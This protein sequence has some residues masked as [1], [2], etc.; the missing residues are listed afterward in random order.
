M[1]GF[2]GKK[3]RKI[4]NKV[5]INENIKWE[6]C[7]QQYQKN[8]DTAFIV[9]FEE[10]YEK[11]ISFFSVDN[12]PADNIFLTRQALHHQLQHV[13]VLFAEHHPLRTREEEFLDKHQL[14]HVTVYSSLD[15]PLLKHFGSSDITDLI[16]QSGMKE[17]EP[18]E[19]P[20][21]NTAIENAQNK[22]AEQVVL[23][24]AAFSQADW[25]MKNLTA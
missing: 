20:L 3:E 6:Q 17:D 5:W 8:N 14:T 21:I 12:L 23:E 15:E 1:F 13:P 22:I 25:L 24:I 9:W 16:K 7:K 18:I 4:T 19:H 10:T 2:L 11:L